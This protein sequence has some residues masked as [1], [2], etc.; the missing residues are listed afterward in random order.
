LQKLRTE[1][2][3]RTFAHLYE[4]GGMRRLHL[5]GRENV[6]KRLLVHAAGFNL[7]LV[8]RQMLRVGKLRQLQGLAAYFLGDLKHLPSLISAPFTLCSRSATVSAV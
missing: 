3:E 7:K 5:N 4:T 1:L 2:R 8:M 6:L